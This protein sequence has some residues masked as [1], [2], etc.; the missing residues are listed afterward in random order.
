MARKKQAHY[1]DLESEIIKIEHVNGWADNDELMDRHDNLLKKLEERSNYITDGIILR[2]K[3][4]WYERG[5][6]KTIN[7]F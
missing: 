1:A 2:S 4:T 3:A 7:T 6:K 5:E